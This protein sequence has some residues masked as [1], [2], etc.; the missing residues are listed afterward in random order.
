M[1]AAEE[2]QK[3]IKELNIASR[4]KIKLLKDRE[5][6]VTEEAEKI[7]RNFDEGESNFLFSILNRQ[8]VQGD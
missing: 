2:F 6:E 8:R 1:L 3:S 5:L 4:R 7:I